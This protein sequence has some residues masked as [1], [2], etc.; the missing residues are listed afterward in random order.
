MEKDQHTSIKNLINSKYPN[1]VKNWGDSAQLLSFNQ[2]IELIDLHT[3]NKD[4][5]IKQMRW[6]YERALLRVLACNSRFSRMNDAY[7]DYIQL[8]NDELTELAS[9]ALFNGW[10]STRKEHGIYL[11]S[12]IEDILKEDKYEPDGRETPL[13]DFELSVRL[14]HSLKCMNIKTLEQVLEKTE[15][16]FIKNRSF[17]KRSLKELKE[18]LGTQK[19]SLKTNITNDYNKT[20][21]LLDFEKIVQEIK[22]NPTLHGIAILRNILIKSSE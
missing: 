14:F 6:D 7:N 2:I 10:E 16:D 9:S 4:K 3:K 19:L 13:I 12:C 20:V 11:R 22:A 8:L 5:Y 17:G 21:I 15:E 18:F 1:L